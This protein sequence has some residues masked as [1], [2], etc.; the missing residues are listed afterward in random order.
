[1]V[2][3]TFTTQCIGRQSN[4]VSGL[5][6]LRS[7]GR[8]M[9]AE[10]SLTPLLLLRGERQLTAA[11]TAHKQAL[12][13][14]TG[15]PNTAEGGVSTVE[16]VSAGVAIVVPGVGLHRSMLGAPQ[17]Q[18]RSQRH[19]ESW[20]YARCWCRKRGRLMFGRQRAATVD[21]GDGPD[22]HQRVVQTLR[23]SPERNSV[24]SCR[25]T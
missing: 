20:C 12:G 10:Q 1:M 24:E 21:A 15:E 13:L 3:A 17:R 6:S 5:T 22:L 14:L 23:G 19:P 18:P 4:T 9:C 16:V 2:R 25:I 11:V 7:P 8:S